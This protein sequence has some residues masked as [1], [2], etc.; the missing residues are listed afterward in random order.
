MNR[1][2][3]RL[4]TVAFTLL[5]GAAILI[6]TPV[7]PGQQPATGDPAATPPPATAWRQGRI[8]DSLALASAKQQQVVVYFWMSGSQHCTNLWGQTLTTPAA[9]AELGQFV[10][11]GADVATP[12]G[13]TL[14]QRY[15]VKTLPTLLVLNANGIVDDAMI[16]FVPLATFVSE[17]QRIRA[18]NGTVTALRAA[19]DAA[20]ADLDKRFALGQKLAFVGDATAGQVV[21]DSIRRDDPEGKTSPGAELLL[22]EVQNAILAQAPDKNDPATWTLEPMYERLRRT[23]QDPVR[24]KGWNWLARI[25]AARGAPRKQVDAWR[26]AWPHAPDNLA[27]EW[28]ADILDN[29]WQRRDTVRPKGRALAREL[30]RELGRRDKG[31]DD[32]PTQKAELRGVLLS[33]AA[34]GLAIGG[35][36]RQALQLLARARGLTPDDPK[37][38]EL[39]QQIKRQ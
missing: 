16:G 22:F 2:Q 30:G 23:K 26:A 39:Q 28:A 29:L 31:K 9:A 37:L 5:G 11:H 14:V 18:G 27:E 20:P 35:K 10:C 15:N 33:A 36:K 24:W 3:R 6:A 13:A 7:L 17:M 34:R 4:A 12:A 8:E 21:W 19:A 38:D 1:A 32:D 25:E